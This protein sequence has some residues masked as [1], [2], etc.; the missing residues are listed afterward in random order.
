MIDITFQKKKGGILIELIDILDN[1]LSTK[2]LYW[3]IFFQVNDFSKLGTF[4][5]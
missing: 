3:K 4:T 1:Y 5:D 2:D